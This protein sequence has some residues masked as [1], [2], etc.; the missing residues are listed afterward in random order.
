MERS[1]KFVSLLI[2]LNDSQGE[3]PEKILRMLAA[4]LKKS[5]DDIRNILETSKLRLTKVAVNLDLE[6]LIAILE[7][8]GL[9]VQ[10]TFLEADASVQEAPARSQRLMQGSSSLPAA[11]SEDRTDWKKGDVIEG[12]YEVLG[13]AKGGMGKVYFV[14]HRLW[15]MML[16]IK[17][18]QRSA[19]KG[20]TQI[21]RFLREAELWVDLG[22]HPNIATCYYARVMNGLPRLFIEYV[23]G[24]TLD[25]WAERNVVK[26]TRT[27][28][29][30]MLQ[31]CHGMIYAEQRGMIH[32]DIKPANCL[33]SRQR[34]LKITDFGLVKRVEDPSLGLV[35]QEIA[36]DVGKAADTSLTM[37]E[38]G[39]LGSPWYMAPERFKHKGKEDIRSDVYSF[40]IMLY[41]VALGTMPFKFPTGF[42]IPTLVKSHLRAQPVDPLSI[43]EDLPRPLATIIMTC[44]EKKP[45]NRYPSFV[46]VC[47][48]LESSYRETWPGREPRVRPNLVGLK[49]DSLNNQAVSLLDLQREQDARKLLED[50][51]SANPEHLEA[52][53]NLHTLK[54]SKGEISDVEVVR[55]LESMRIEVRETDDYRHLMGLVALQRGD[56]ARAVTLLR[57]ASEGNS[58]YRERWKDYDNDPKAFV[59]SLELPVIEEKGSFAGHIKSVLALGFEPGSAR[60]FSVG[61]DRSIRVWDTQSGRCLKNL[62]TFTF[63]PVAG[64][65]SREG[66]LAATCYGNAFKTLDL[67]DLEA[68]RL[69]R[70]Y[71]GME[72]FGMCFSFDAKY[73]AAFGPKPHVRVLDVAANRVESEFS[74]DSGRVTAIAFLADGQSIA[75]GRDDGDLLVQNLKPLEEVWRFQ[76]HRGP[77]STVTLSEDGSEIITGGADETIKIFDSGTGREIDRF[78]GHRATVVSARLTS[79][80]DYLVSAASDGEIKVWD[81]GNKRCCRTLVHAEEELTGTAMSPNGNR[82]LSGGVKGSI[83]VWNLSTAWFG[84]NFLEPAICRPK[85]F[86]ELVGLHDSFTAAIEDFKRVWRKGEHRE[87]LE[88]FERIRGVPGFCWSREAILTRNILGGSSRRMGLTSHC[89]IRS[90]HG[91]TDEVASLAVSPDGLV[92]LSGCL[93]GTAG[94]WDVVTGRRVK[95][96]NVG[97]EVRR[98]T[99]LPRVQ[100][101]LTWST[102]NI[103]R[104]WDL[105]G[106]LVGEI[107]DAHPPISVNEYGSEVMAMSP[108]DEVMA[109]SLETR[110]RNPKGSALPGHNFICFSDNLQMLY[111]VRDGTRIQRWS[112]STGRS[113]GTFRDLGLKII[114]LQPVAKDDKVIAGA[115]TGEIIVYA[116]G[117]GI[118]VANLRGHKSAVHALA[119]EQGGNLLVT[120]S[121]DCSV[122]LW[123]VDAQQCLAIMEGHSAPIRSVSIFPNLSLVASGASDGSMR[124]WGLEWQFAVQ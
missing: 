50:A 43:R 37:F 40:G 39:I 96:F 67:W 79:A 83:R 101:I 32:R 44:L 65:F 81:R 73:L 72:A 47:K 30:L 53:Y 108:D 123:D 42:S 28:V 88:I 103:L 12:L 46:D 78:V 1:A 51:H 111:S 110:E 77:V 122:R 80:K 104:R 70:R 95:R 11:T 98:I 66:R 114:S 62:R 100:G 124:L 3:L 56:A 48:A 99:F 106:N 74:A 52:V 61:E 84:K 69:L 36:Q 55:R 18:P 25:Q 119:A 4:V 14:F 116:V 107:P 15:K 34:A 64:A 38:H 118:N 20:E 94:M 75:V 45:E 19:V 21:L 71:T 17:T 121:D 23:D 9:K 109:I 68:G 49:A 41:Q 22:V 7:K 60:A 59:D 93:D 31:F 92:L 29:D 117:S 6:R 90:F 54:W 85:T 16:A 91:H 86:Q 97:S 112:V 2:S 58:Q 120:G 26:D 113:E 102:D 8:N 13:S 63:V 24:G 57:S 35:S 82:L 10:A 87:A 27:V 76:A 33:I 105:A 115:E 89:F 5:P